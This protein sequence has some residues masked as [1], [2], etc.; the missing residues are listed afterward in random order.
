MRFHKTDPDLSLLLRW[1]LGPYAAL[2]KKLIAEGKLDKHGRPNAE[3]PKVG[4]GVGQPAKGLSPC[5]CAN[6]SHFLTSAQ[7]YLRALPDVEAAAAAKAA[8]APKPVAAA[9][10]ADDLAEAKSPKPM[11][12]EEGAK[13][14]EEKKAKKDVSEGVIEV[15]NVLITDTWG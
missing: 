7:E 9:T 8:S 3:T 12:V 5:T 10:V 4:K 13:G 11:E 15:R 1:G 6:T 14:T 2:K